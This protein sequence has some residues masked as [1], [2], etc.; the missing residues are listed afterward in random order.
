[1]QAYCEKILLKKRTIRHLLRAVIFWKGW[2]W[3][4]GMVRHTVMYICLRSSILTIIL[5]GSKGLELGINIIIIT[6]QDKIISHYFKTNLIWVLHVCTHVCSRKKGAFFVIEVPL[7]NLSSS[8]NFTNSS[9][10]KFPLV[11]WL[12]CI[13]FSNNGIAV[14]Y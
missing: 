13:I 4:G 8:I 14:N 7:T 2:W 10:R 11:A 9:Y 3:W 12:K 6:S 5:F 1:M